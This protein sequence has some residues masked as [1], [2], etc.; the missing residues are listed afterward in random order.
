MTNMLSSS[1]PAKAENGNYKA[2]YYLNTCTERTGTNTRTFSAKAT[3]DVRKKPNTK[4]RSVSSF[5][6]CFGFQSMTKPTIGAK[7]NP[8]N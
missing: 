6:L 3:H 8:A 4:P 1:Y 7:K 2:V 5:C